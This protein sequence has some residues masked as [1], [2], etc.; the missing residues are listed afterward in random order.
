MRQ[1]Q[2]VQIVPRP[3]RKRGRLRYAQTRRFRGK[4]ARFGAVGKLEAGIAGE[5]LVHRQAAERRR[6]RGRNAVFLVPVFKLEIRPHRLG[7]VDWIKGKR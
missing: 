4:R 7:S 5:R 1:E 6:K 3:V 2:F